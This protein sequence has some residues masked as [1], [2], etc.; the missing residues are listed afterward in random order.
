MTT[1]VN[2][3]SGP[4]APATEPRVCVRY[5]DGRT[6]QPY[7]AELIPDATTLIVQ[8]ESGERRHFDWSSLTVLNGVGS[9]AAVLELPEEQRIEL[10]NPEIPAWIQKATGKHW[11]D[12]VRHWEGS[13]RWIALSVVV[14]SALVASFVLLV[15]PAAANWIAWALPE[16]TLKETGDQVLHQ[17]PGSDRGRSRCA[18]SC[19]AAHDLSS[20]GV[21]QHAAHRNLPRVGRGA[22]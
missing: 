12:K 15:V 4:A 6:S 2:T 20:L 14:I 21:V 19:R 8:L 7:A 5:F 9:V 17:K 18:R 11:L 3:S 22:Q 1:S 10:P 13:L 16:S